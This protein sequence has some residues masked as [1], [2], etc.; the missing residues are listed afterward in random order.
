MLQM[1]LELVV[2]IQLPD[3]VKM[4]SLLVKNMDYQHIVL[5]I[6]EDS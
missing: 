3:M 4:I 1:I 2:F 5:L 6:L